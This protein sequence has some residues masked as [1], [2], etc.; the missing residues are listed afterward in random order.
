[1][2]ARLEVF[3]L[4]EWQRF[5]A[6]QLLLQPLSWLFIFVTSIRRLCFRFGL[7]STHRLRVPVVVVGNI[8]VGGTGKTP[9]VLA[10]SQYLL[11]LGSHPGVV[12]RGYS[13]GS[14]APINTRAVTVQS[15]ATESVERTNFSDEATVLA[16]RAGVPVYVGRDRV[17]A[18]K[19]MLRQ[20]VGVDVILS[21]D[22]LQHYAL[23]RDVEIAVVDIERGFGNGACL[24]AGPLRESVSRLSDVDCIVLNCPS[25]VAG[26]GRHESERSEAWKPDEAA[27]SLRVRLEKEAGGRPVF[28]MRYASERFISIGERGQVGGEHSVGDDLLL[29]DFLREV[30]GKRVVAL[31]GI[32]NPERFFGHLQRLGVV[33]AETIV[34]PDHHPFSSADLVGITA[35]II[36]MTEKDAV[37][38]RQFADSRAWMMRVDAELP[39]AFY[40][41]VVKKIAHVARSKVA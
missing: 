24:P 30:A 26:D 33:V 9:V 3:F 21:D 15:A 19:T 18:A 20:E 34:F 29:V 39:D 10:L 4:R 22:G 1:M 38:C 13:R 7:M 40:E 35:D 41:F 12:T 17:R 23:G 5:S 6:W 8:S 37:K 31:A 11:R 32:G 2:A 27:P 16:E 28:E 14:A 36:L 25:A